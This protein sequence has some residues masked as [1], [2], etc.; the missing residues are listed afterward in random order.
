MVIYFLFCAYHPNIIV[1]SS[2]F[3]FQ[4]WSGLDDGLHSPSIMLY[5]EWLAWWRQLQL[6]SHGTSDWEQRW[7]QVLST[8]RLRLLMRRGKD[9]LCGR[10]FLFL[11]KE[12]C[13]LMD[14]EAAEDHAFM[15]FWTNTCTYWQGLLFRGQNYYICLIVWNS[16]CCILKQQLGESPQTQAI[17]FC[18]ESSGRGDLE[19]EIPPSG[20]S[21]CPSCVIEGAEKQHQ[22]LDVIAMHDMVTSLDVIIFL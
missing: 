20:G 18:W 13:V 4:K 3:Q 6:L 12:L 11:F 2:H 1:N 14:I 17:R 9:H 8:T 7:E 15:A 21:P 22:M 16:V 5:H 10:N 19:S